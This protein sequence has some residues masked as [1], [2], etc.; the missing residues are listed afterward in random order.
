MAG[1]ITTASGTRF[2]V[3]PSVASTI[4]TVNAYS[5]L[6]YVEVGL[7]ESFGEYGDDSA[8]VTF[9]AVGDARVRHSKGARDAGTM[10]LVVGHDPFDAGQLAL[11]AAE[12]TNHN[13]AFKIILPD[14]PTASSADTVNYFRGLV[15]SK[16]LNV[17]ANNNVI[18]RT[19]NIG[20]NSE[21]YETPATV[22]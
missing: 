22:F 21:I 4:N 10:A 9:S 7:I 6:S 20:I 17:G 15:K 8:D 16:K 19:F 5:A 1:D 18:K 11:I 3:G 14:G 13:F 12:A 2:Y